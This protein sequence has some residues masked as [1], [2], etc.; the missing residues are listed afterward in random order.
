MASGEY[1]DVIRGRDW[2]TARL[3]ERIFGLLA[4]VRKVPYTQGGIDQVVS[5][6]DA[7]LREGIGAGYLSGDIPEGQELPFIVT[8][9]EI[10]DISQADK[11]ARLLPDVAFTATLAGAIHAVEI[12]GT[13]QV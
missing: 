8:A 2:L 11:I 5:Q 10:G 12:N 3:R 1:I 6:V 4:N 13:I 7:Q 9:P